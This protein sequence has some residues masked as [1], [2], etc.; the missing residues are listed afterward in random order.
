M[1]VEAPRTVLGAAIAELIPDPQQRA[2]IDA[3]RFSWLS[4]GAG[5][6]GG[7]GGL[8]A[9]WLSIPALYWINGI[10][11]AAFA[12]VAGCAMPSSTRHGVVARKAVYRQAF[13]DSRLVLLFLASVA[14]LTA[15]MGFYAAMPMLMSRYGLDPG[16]YGRAQLANAAAVVALTPLITPW[17]S[18]RVQH[19]PR[20]D[21]WPP[22]WCGQLSPSG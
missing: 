15:F 10:A 3:L 7:V 14:T 12:V 11:A 13:S 18:Q 22:P 1:E 21:I 16:A 6:A 8:L 5:I 17:V 2:K 9:G 4:I 19:R 20:I